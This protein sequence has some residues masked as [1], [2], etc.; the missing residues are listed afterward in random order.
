MFYSFQSSDSSRKRPSV[1]LDMFSGRPATFNSNNGL[2]ELEVDEAASYCQH[3]PSHRVSA[4]GV[5]M[6]TASL[7]NK[8][9]NKM[10]RVSMQR[11]SISVDTQRL[12]NQLLTPRS[13][14]RTGRRFTFGR[15]PSASTSMSSSSRFKHLTGGNNKNNNNV[16]ENNDIRGNACNSDQDVDGIIGESDEHLNDLIEEDP[17]LPPPPPPSNTELEV[18]KDKDKVANILTINETTNIE[19][20]TK[21]PSTPPPPQDELRETDSEQKAVTTTAS[22]KKKHFQLQL[23]NRH[24]KGRQTAPRKTESTSLSE[25]SSPSLSN[26]ESK[27][28]VESDANKTSTPPLP[29]PPL[30]KLSPSSNEG[31]S[32]SGD[33]AGDSFLNVFQLNSTLD[34]DRKRCVLNVGGVRSEVMWK[35]LERLPTSRL[36]RLRYARTMDEANELCDDYDADENEFFFDRNPRSFSAVLNYYRTGKLHLV[37]DICVLSFHEDLTYWGVSEYLLET[38]CQQKYHQKKELV[39]EEI[40]KEE[41]SLRKQIQEEDFGKWCPKIRK[42]VWDLMENPQTSKSAR[43]CFTNKFKS[44]N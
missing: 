40:R 14:H 11:A 43:V 7:R 10:R 44:S 4:D 39:M 23:F 17:P 12:Q 22:T 16:E 36:H 21:S 41:E 2:S 31:G 1:T 38:C 34:L 42:R 18:D 29:T 30:M 19:Q 32:E 33:G 5:E 25:H 8:E 26:K 35:T 15:K 37:E 3:N 13:S 9:L 24:A 28:V 27:R 20:T 6:S